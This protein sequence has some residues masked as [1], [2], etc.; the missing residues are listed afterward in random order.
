MLYMTEDVNS[1]EEEGFR[2][3]VSADNHSLQ[4]PV[5]D[6]KVA[7]DERMD[8]LWERF[9]DD[10]PLLGRISPVSSTVTVTV[11]MINRES[12]GMVHASLSSG[13]RNRRGRG[14]GSFMLV[15]RLLGKF[16]PLRKVSPPRA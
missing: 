9:N 7:D 15:L 11:P 12:M 13:G 8:R 10:L 2:F 14:H 5:V 3:L 1:D 16:F 6:G 4:S